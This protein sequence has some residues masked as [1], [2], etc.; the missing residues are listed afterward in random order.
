MIAHFFM[1]AVYKNHGSDTIS[2]WREYY[3]PTKRHGRNGTQ[4]GQGACQDKERLLR[5]ASAQSAT[6]CKGDKASK[7]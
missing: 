6:W 2:E 5:I 7:L 3:Y 1:F 4:E